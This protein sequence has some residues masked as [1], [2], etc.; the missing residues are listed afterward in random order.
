M[1]RSGRRRSRSA[2]RLLSR[3]AGADFL[4]RLGKEDGEWRL[5][6]IDFG[7][8]AQHDDC[9]FLMCFAFQATKADLAATSPYVEVGF[10]LPVR[11]GIGGSMFILT[12]Q[13]ATGLQQ[14]DVTKI[15]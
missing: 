9:E 14:D 11:S 8:E 7:I 6:A 5:V 3:G 4:V 2:E 15:G 10:A 12:I 1:S 13:T